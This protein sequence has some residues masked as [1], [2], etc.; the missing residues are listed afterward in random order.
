M[1][2]LLLA[3]SIALAACSPRYIDGW[4]V[5]SPSGCESDV[6]C[7]DLQ[8]VATAGLDKKYPGHAPVRSVRIHDEGPQ[9]NGQVITRIGAWIHVAVF[10]LADGS[11]HAIGVGYLGISR[12]AR[13]FDHP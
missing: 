11:A 6:H 12:T 10:N 7:D 13:T 5:G 2:R 1:K 3:L 8:A 9:R 4:S